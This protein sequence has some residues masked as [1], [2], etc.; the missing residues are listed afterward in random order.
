VTLMDYYVANTGEIVPGPGHF[1]QQITPSPRRPDAGEQPEIER[2]AFAVLTDS[3]ELPIAFVEEVR[4]RPEETARIIVSESARPLAEPR[5]PWFYRG[6]RRW[7]RSR[8]A[9]T[10]ATAEARGRRDGA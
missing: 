2:K 4:P 6:T 10:A 5:R 8:A 1:T 3:G 9:L 7:T